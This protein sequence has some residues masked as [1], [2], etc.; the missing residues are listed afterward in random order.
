MT[1]SELAKSGTEHGE[2]AALFAWARM[3]EK[4]GFSAANDPRSYSSSVTALEYWE[5]S[6]TPEAAVRGCL[7]LLHAIPNGGQRHKAVAGKMKAEGVKRGVPDVCLPVPRGP[8]H[9]LYIEMKK[10]GE[11]KSTSDDQRFWI[12]NLRLLGYYAVVRDSWHT[13][14]ATIQEYLTCATNLRIENEPIIY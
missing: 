5:R 3:A 10:A 14:A 11:L 12:R 2:Q 1:P 13:A 6:D 4:Y 7:A 8:W 9:G